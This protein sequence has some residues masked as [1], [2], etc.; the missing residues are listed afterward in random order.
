MFLGHPDVE[1]GGVIDGDVLSACTALLHSTLNN[2][3]YSP[4]RNALNAEL[5]SLRSI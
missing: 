1:S 4:G 3:L 5:A 2:E